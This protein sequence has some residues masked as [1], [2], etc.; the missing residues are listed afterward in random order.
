MHKNGLLIRVLKKI[1][2]GSLTVCVCFSRENSLK[3]LFKNGFYVF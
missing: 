1:S 2:N 3:L